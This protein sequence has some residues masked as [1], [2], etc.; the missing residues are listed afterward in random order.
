MGHRLLF[1]GAGKIAQSVIKGLLNRGQQESGL[2]KDLE[3]LAVAPTCNNRDK[4]K[5]FQ[6]NTRRLTNNLDPIIQVNPHVV[7]LCVK[8]QILKKSKDDPLAKL[9]K[10][11]HADCLVVS[12][13]AGITTTSIKCSFSHDFPKYNI[14]R[15]MVNLAAEINQTNAFLYL[16]SDFK[17][18]N[19]PKIKQLF[20]RFAPTITTVPDESLMDVCTG[21]TGSGIAFLYE[22][23]QAISDIGV[24]NGLGREA[25]TRA[26]AQLSMAAGA[27]CLLTNSHPHQLRDD[28]ATPSGCTISGLKK[29]EENSINYKIGQAFQE[30]ID[31][32]KCI[33]E[34]K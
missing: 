7:F 20:E 33:D 15:A 24:M 16:S 6:V 9:L 31:K 23:I 14:I 19:I 12:V 3:I 1:I 10:S 11:I 29:W 30:S 4:L 22:V 27:M 8:P 26:A 17:K 13:M 2:V 28:V 5:S 21:L 34:N 18:E 32:A 25:S